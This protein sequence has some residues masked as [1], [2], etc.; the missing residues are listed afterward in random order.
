MRW[1][2]HYP[3]DNVIMIV[4]DTAFPLTDPFNPP[5]EKQRPPEPLLSLMMFDQVNQFQGS[6]TS[7]MHYVILCAL[8]SLIL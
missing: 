1:V 7:S 5:Y 3:Q 8:T 4:F 6:V 2:S